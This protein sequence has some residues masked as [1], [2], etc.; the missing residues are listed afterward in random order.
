MS[1]SRKNSLEHWKQ[2]NRIYVLTLYPSGNQETDL[3]R[4]SRS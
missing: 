2:S 4:H 3:P 1:S